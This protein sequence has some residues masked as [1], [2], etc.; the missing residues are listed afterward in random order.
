ML[1]IINKYHPKI[2]VWGKNDIQA[3]QASYKL[4]NKK[5]LTKS[6]DFVDLSKLHKDYFNLRD[7]LGLFK[8]YETY[9]KKAKEQIHS[10][11]EDAKITKN[12]FEAFIT[13][14]NSD[15]NGK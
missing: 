7:D 12:V 14:I 9:Y 2:V 10:A 13:Y 11:K 4:H 1:T 8:A 5:A 6:T 3:I 15:I